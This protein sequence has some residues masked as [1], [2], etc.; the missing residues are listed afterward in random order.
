MSLLGSPVVLGSA[1]QVSCRPQLCCSPSLLKALCLS[2]HPREHTAPTL[3]REEK[4]QSSSHLKRFLSLCRD[5]EG[6]SCKLSAVLLVG[7][8]PSSY[9]PPHS[10]PALAMPCVHPARHSFFFFPPSPWLN[11]RHLLK[12]VSHVCRLRT[13]SGRNEIRASKI[14]ILLIVKLNAKPASKNSTRVSLH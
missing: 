12:Y 14:A 8:G 7:Q 6:Q 3:C 4:R 2:E 1:S 13:S 11:L 5:G 10:V 9:T